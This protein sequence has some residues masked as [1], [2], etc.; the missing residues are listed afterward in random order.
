LKNFNK[1]ALEQTLTNNKSKEFC[2][3]QKEELYSFKQSSSVLPHKIFI[4]EVKALDQ[5]RKLND[6]NTA[7]HCAYKRKM[8]VENVLRIYPQ[9]GY[10]Q[11]DEHKNGILNPAFLGPFLGEEK[12]KEYMQ[13]KAFVAGLL[14]TPV[15]TSEGVT[16]NPVSIFRKSRFFEPKLIKLLF[17]FLHKSVQI[18]ET[19]IDYLEEA[20][21]ITFKK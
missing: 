21:T 20:K 19:P 2:K 11:I 12:E 10:A 8:K 7:A 5:K 4:V 1:E 9:I 18:K 16:I 6:W 15:K 13:Q 17:S 3:Y 14:E